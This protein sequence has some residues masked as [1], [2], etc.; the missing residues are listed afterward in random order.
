MVTR[1]VASQRSLRRHSARELERRWSGLE[2]RQVVAD[3]VPGRLGSD[4]AG[5]GER[6]FAESAHGH[7]RE[8]ARLIEARRGRT[9]YF[10]KTVREKPRLRQSD[11]C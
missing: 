9:A 10:A 11:T 8:A 7:D 1:Y 5:S 6:V 4:V 2:L 3:G